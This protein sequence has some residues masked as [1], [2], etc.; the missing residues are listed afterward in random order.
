MAKSGSLAQKAAELGFKNE[1]DFRGCGQC[2]IAAVTD[3]LELKRDELFK[4]ATA[5]AGGVGLMGDGCC[6]A[7]LGGVMLIGDR[8][9]RT[10]DNLADPEGERF[11]AY[12]LAADFHRYFVEEYGTVICRDI[13]TK[14]MGRPFFIADKDEMAKF[15][16][17]GG[18]FDKCP[19][20]VG[21]ASGWL[22]E[23][24]EKNGMLEPP[25]GE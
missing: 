14:T 9:G 7:Y 16:E 18:H 13:H 24:L 6:G 25:E 15:D 20:V 11:K 17:A 3:T 1:K 5:L 10:R 22:V 21:K 8:V 19:A 12:K 2:L 4:S 23:L